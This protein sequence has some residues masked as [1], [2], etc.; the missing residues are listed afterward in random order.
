MDLFAQ[1]KMVLPLARQETFVLGRD[2]ETIMIID[3]LNC[4]RNSGKKM[5][6]QPDFG[7]EESGISNLLADVD[8]STAAALKGKHLQGLILSLSSPKV[9]R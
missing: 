6:N 4:V 9:R 1:T 5:K 8:Q 3:I 2:P 7:E